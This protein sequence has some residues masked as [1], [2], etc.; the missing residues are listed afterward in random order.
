MGDAATACM[1]KEKYNNCAQAQNGVYAWALHH[2]TPELMAALVVY[3]CL[4]CEF[5]HAGNSEPKSIRSSV[6]HSD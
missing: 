5:W 4:H 6:S 2:N 1:G 3:D